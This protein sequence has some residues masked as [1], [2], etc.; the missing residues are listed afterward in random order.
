[1]P[2]LQRSLL[3]EEGTKVRPYR[4][5][6]LPIFSKLSEEEKKSAIEM[7]STVLSVFEEVRAEGGKLRDDARLVWRALSKLGWTPCS[8]VFSLMRDGDIICFHDL[9]QRLVFQNLNFFDWV[10]YTLEDLYGGLWYVLSKRNEKTAE[11]L[12]EAVMK[13]FQ[14]DRTFEPDVEEHLMEEVGTEGLLKFMIRVQYMSPLKS[15]GQT[16]GLLLINRCRSVK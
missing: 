8:D 7:V 4:S 14:T 11:S 3:A 13:A 10:S 15:N 12:Y 2:L 16:T 6:D 5:P 1:M 9:R